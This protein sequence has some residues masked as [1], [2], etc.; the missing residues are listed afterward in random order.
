MGVTGILCV[1][2]HDAVTK[3]CVAPVSTNT[4]AEWDSTE[5]VLS[6]TPGVS[7]TLSTS[8]WLTFPY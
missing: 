2:T 1:S 8:R 5:N 7:Y 4:F 6:A 3:E